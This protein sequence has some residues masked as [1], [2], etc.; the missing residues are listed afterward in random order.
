MNFMIKYV[1]FLQTSTQESEKG[2]L[3]C[4]HL[5]RRNFIAKKLRYTTSVAYVRH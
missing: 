5:G 1:V 4:Y 2:K 3:M